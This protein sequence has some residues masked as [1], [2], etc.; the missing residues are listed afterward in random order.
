M[1]K[2]QSIKPALDNRS[3]QKNPIDVRYYESRGIA[4]P[5]LNQVKTSTNSTPKKNRLT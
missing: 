2:T 3:R 5:K 1:K 4:K